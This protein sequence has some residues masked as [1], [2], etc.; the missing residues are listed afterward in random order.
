MRGTGAAR[1]TARGMQRVQAVGRCEPGRVRAPASRT[2]VV[3]TYRK[4]ASGLHE[5]RSFLNE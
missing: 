3:D 1:A 5:R 4:H 2:D